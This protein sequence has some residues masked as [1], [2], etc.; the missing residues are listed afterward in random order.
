MTDLQ[1]RANEN[2]E[3]AL[4]ASGARDPREFFR[5]RLREL[6]QD[7]AGAYEQAVAYYTH[8]LVPDVAA[9]D[10]DPLVAW[11]EYGRRL[12]EL[13]AP[14]RTLSLDPEG[15]AEAYEAPA[16][17]D[18]LVL[19]LPDGSRGRALLVALPRDPSPAQRAA[20]DLLVE[21]RQKLPD[22]LQPRTAREEE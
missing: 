8:T 15:R 6:K 22:D 10:V 17:P 12:A 19:H 2:L 20:Y 4:S 5:A 7:D 16:A 3:A 11:T 21:G 18:R 9:G 13:S 14:G 1:E